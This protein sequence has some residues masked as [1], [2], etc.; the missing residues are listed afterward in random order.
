MQA[1]SKLRLFVTKAFAKGSFEEVLRVS[2]VFQVLNGLRGNRAD[3]LGEFVLTHLGSFPGLNGVVLTTADAENGPWLLW[4]SF[5]G[6]IDHPAHVKVA[7]VQKSQEPVNLDV[8]LLQWLPHHCL[9]TASPTTQPQP[10]N[11]CWRYVGRTATESHETV[12]RRQNDTLATVGW[13][14]KV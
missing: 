11:T 2:K 13:I 9:T 7:G 12:G 4:R 6:R 3:K 14:A 5:F 10:P 1:G 8:P